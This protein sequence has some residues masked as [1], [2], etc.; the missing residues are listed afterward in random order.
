MKKK[1]KKSKKNML[2]VSKPYL[3]RT[4][5]ALLVI[6]PYLSQGG[7]GAVPRDRTGRVVDEK[8]IDF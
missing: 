6:Y 5:Y 3:E 4:T 7:G 1:G 8:Y 2:Y